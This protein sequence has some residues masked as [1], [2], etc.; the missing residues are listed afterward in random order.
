MNVG[1]PLLNGGMT[2]LPDTLE[3]LTRQLAAV[4]SE[5]WS[6][7]RV[8]VL[9]RVGEVQRMLDAMVIDVVDDIETAD[10]LRQQGDRATSRA[11]CRSTAELL[12]RTLLID[13]PAARRYSSAAEAAHEDVAVSSGERLP[14]DFPELSATLRAGEVSLAGFLACVLPL[15]KA[16]PR[17]A[18]GD[19]ALADAVLAR[20][21]TGR[22]VDAIDDADGSGDGVERGPSLTP[23]ELTA[24]VAHLLLRLDPD[25]ADPDDGTGDRTRSFSI[26]RL[27]NGTVPVQGRLLPEAAAALQRLFDA[28]NNPR[29]EFA[30]GTADGS[31]EADITP[32][33]GPD[34][35]FDPDAPPEAAADTR[36]PA[37]MRHD[38]F[39]AIIM[40]EGVA[41]AAPKLGGAAPTLL[42]SVRAE[43]YVSGK[44]RAHLESTGW[45]V[46]LSVA[47]HVA[48]AGGVQRVLLDEYGAIVGI[49][50]TGRIFTTHQRRAIQLRDRECLIPGCDVRADWCEIHHVE[51]WARGGPTHTSNGVALCWHHHRTLETSGWQIRMQDGIP[52]IRGPA[53]WDPYCRWRSPQHGYRA[54]DRALAGARGG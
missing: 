15:R 17:I 39:A 34:D 18:P 31:D 9:C 52:Q 14:G 43:D 11:G 4:R 50:T 41:G 13:R 45:N 47:Q 3:G 25:G 37:Q 24:L 26:G 2:N 23:E 7:D 27:R 53:W 33:S 16:Q 28:Y 36:T 35:D 51:E 19:L 54:I 29:V 12:Q 8:E 22:D 38:A 32:G 40:S 46:P 48:C 10:A 42:V 6:G 49:S 44:G 1:G 21:A 30:S 20:A 5:A